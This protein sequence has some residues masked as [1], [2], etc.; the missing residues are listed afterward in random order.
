MYSEEKVVLPV[1]DESF[2]T[3]SYFTNPAALHSTTGKTAIYPYMALTWFEC[4][5]PPLPCLQYVGIC[6]Y[7]NLVPL[8]L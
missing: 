6:E 4:K 5:P 2:E 8:H 3:A 1:S 7:S